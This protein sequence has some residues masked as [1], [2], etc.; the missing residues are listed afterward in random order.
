VL[1]DDDEGRLRARILAEEHRLL[2]AAVRA[3]VEGRLVLDGRRV[4]VRPAPL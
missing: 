4:R 3:A 2:P 1:D